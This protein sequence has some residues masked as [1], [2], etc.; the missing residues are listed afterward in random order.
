VWA[1][2]GD[3]FAFGLISLTLDEV[4]AAELLRVADPK[5]VRRQAIVSCEP[6]RSPGGKRFVA[7]ALFCSGAGRQTHAIV[8]TGLVGDTL[9]AECVAHE[10]LRQ[11]S[12][13]RR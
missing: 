3:R 2:V 8:G 13:L 6:S 12:A 7:V 10:L 5:S 1:H 9:G 4:D 11:P